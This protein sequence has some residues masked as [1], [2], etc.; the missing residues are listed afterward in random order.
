MTGPTPQAPTPTSQLDRTV[1]TLRAAAPAW[2]G[3][4]IGERIAHLR[5]LL[6][7]TAEVG[8]ALVD[9]ALAAKGVDGRF[10][11]EEWVGAVAIQARVLRVLIDTLEGIE[12][13]GRVP[14]PASAVSTR[15]DGQVVVR[16]TPFDV[17]DRA[18]FTGW[19]GEVWLE[20]EVTLDGL[21]A[22]LGGF[23][24]KGGAA[25]P[26]VSAVM[27]AGNV[28]CIAPTDAVHKLFVEGKA[29]VVKL[30]PVNDY[31][32]PFLERVF[33]DLID[34]GCVGV[35]YGGAGVGE[36]LVHH[37]LVT[38]VHLTGSAATYDAIVYGTGPEGAARKERGERLLDKS[39]TAELGNVSPVIVVPGEWSAG[40][41]RFQA[42]HI[43]TQMKHND[44]FNCNAAKVLVLAAGWAQ[45]EAFLGE[46]RRVIGFL[47]PR[48]AYYPGAIERWEAFTASHPDVEL[49]GPV[50]PGRVPATLLL[51]VPAGSGHKA[52]TD[53]AFC[54][55]T[56]VVELDA[57]GPQRFLE[58]AVA[59]ANDELTG[60]LNATILADP[61]AVAALGGGLDAA[62]AG[63]R[64][65]SVGVNM[66]GGATYALGATVWGGFPAADG[67]PTPSGVGFVH[68]GRLIDRPQKSVLWAPFR[69]RPKPPWFLT[70]RNGNRAMR[71]F[72]RFETAPGPL[73]LARVA[74][75]SLRG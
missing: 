70:H 57:D 11:G 75:A 54:A 37:P 44:G 64:Y 25:E 69:I 31:I 19:R 67:E 50:A 55:V 6:R 74:A 36:H 29:A 33:A 58:R 26:G 47:P 53:E 10:A 48:P 71:H 15:P 52:F 30:N 38:D 66:W 68:N 73:T 51:G 62:V 8:P 34:A 4:P 9:A 63:L 2:A 7:R 40:D 20:P 41:L 24:T 56:A 45:K 28:A 43:A 13:H 18:L 23:Y 27:G 49:L 59:F 60:T 65:G 35:A 72:A 14:I 17:Y 39:I 42:E 5:T 3:A 1:E 22:A 61:G 46:L 21:D 16:V 12:R 32:G